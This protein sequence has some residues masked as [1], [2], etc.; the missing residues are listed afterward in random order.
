MTNQTNKSTITH[1]DD[2]SFTSVQVIAWSCALATEAVVIVVGNLLT[3]TLFALNKKLR[4]KKSLYLVLNMAFADLFLGGVCLPM[5]VYFLAHGQVKFSMVRLNSPT[6]FTIIGF[7]F[8]DAS[9][10]T[11][12]LISCERF[13]AIYWPLKH[14]Q[15]LS[16]R[17]YRLVIFTVWTLS[18]L[19]SLLKVFLLQFVSLGA[20]NSLV[21]L[22][23]VSVL[24]IISGLNFGVWRKIQKQPVPHHQNRALQRRRLTKTLLLVSLIALGSWLPPFIYSLISLLGYRMSNTISVI[25]YFTYFSNSFINPILY[26]LRIPDFKEALRLC[27]FTKHE[28][29]SSQ[30][31]AGRDEMAADLTLV[32]QRQTLTV[33][34]NN[35]Q[36]TFEQEIVQDTKLWYTLEEQ[37]T[38]VKKGSWLVKT[39]PEENNMVPN[40]FD[41]WILLEPNFSWALWSILPWTL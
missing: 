34:H 40:S 29:M 39:W 36:L 26:A 3:I 20:L 14:R 11:A 35:L 38:M 33:D 24:L 32:L 1:P 9:F 17:A 31:N 13:Y 15:T 30:E 28:V 6:F 12:A 18:I 23:F 25:T 27:C 8:G 41:N 16:T 5:Y 10:I 21:C 4:S 2:M 7:V 19:G 22:I 37:Q